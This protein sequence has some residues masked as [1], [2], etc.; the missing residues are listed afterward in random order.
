[1]LKKKKDLYHGLSLSDGFQQKHIKLNSMFTWAS[2]GFCILCDE[3][4]LKKKNS[5]ETQETLGFF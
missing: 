3:A 5:I 1:M 4:T 2:Y